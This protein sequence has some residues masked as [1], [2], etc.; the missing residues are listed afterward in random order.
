VPDDARYSDVTGNATPDVTPDV[1]LMRA[2]SLL[3]L[4]RSLASAKGAD[5]IEAQILRLIG[6][7]A[8]DISGRDGVRGF[9][10]LGR[11]MWKFARQR[12]SGASMR[13]WWSWFAAMGL[14]PGPRLCMWEGRWRA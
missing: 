1:T 5:E 3:F 14:C 9:I 6:D 4:F 8:G 7:L 11:G 12:K 10:L 2:C 13:A